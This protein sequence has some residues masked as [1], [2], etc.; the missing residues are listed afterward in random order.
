MILSV[1]KI[2]PPPGREHA[3]ID[4]LDSLTGPVSALA[5]CLGSSVSVETGA[6]EVISYTEKWSS[7]EALDRH[8]NSSLYRRV[9]EAMECSCKQ[10]EVEFYDVTEV[11]GLELVKLARSD[12]RRH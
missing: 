5:G 1:V 8:L 7:R 3:I 9:L 10:P 4:V 12:V 11:G 6:G 2:Y